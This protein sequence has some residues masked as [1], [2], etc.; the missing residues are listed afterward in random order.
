MLIKFF[1]IHRWKGLFKCRV[2]SAKDWTNLIL[3][4]NKLCPG[5]K[6]GTFGSYIK[7]FRGKSIITNSSITNLSVSRSILLVY[8]F[9]HLWTLYK[10]S[11]SVAQNHRPSGLEGSPSQLLCSFNSLCDMHTNGCPTH[12]W[13]L[14]Q[15]TCYP[16]FS[17]F[18]VWR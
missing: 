18:L 4:E 7:H 3:L 14:Q 10:I 5:N 15:G 12:A 11:T 9:G 6:F 16:P 17:L 8:I 13:F 2:L 1:E